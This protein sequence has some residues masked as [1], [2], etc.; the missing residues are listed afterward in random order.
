MRP[1]VLRLMQIEM[2]TSAFLSCP[3]DLK[4]RGA[5]SLRICKGRR[6]LPSAPTSAFGH[7]QSSR[8]KAT[9]STAE[10]ASVANEA[11]VIAV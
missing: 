6:R 4:N 2:L 3:N 5:E 11:L 7:K 8:R 1:S 10:N 9:S